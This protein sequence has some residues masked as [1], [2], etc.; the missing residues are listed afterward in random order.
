M[1]QAESEFIQ[2]QDA[3]KKDLTVEQIVQKYWKK[4]DRKMVGIVLKNGAKK[5]Y[6]TTHCSLANS[7]FLKLCYDFWKSTKEKENSIIEEKNAC[8][9]RWYKYLDP[10]NEGVVG[11]SEVKAYVSTG[12]PLNV[13]TPP[14]FVAC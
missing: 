10:Q 9:T 5:V 8:V 4:F 14:F 1:G 11:W 6:C 2:E 12:V 7:Q 3:A 13:L